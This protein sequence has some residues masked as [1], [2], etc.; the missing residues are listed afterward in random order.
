MKK[1]DILNIIDDLVLDF[2]IYDREEDEDI[3]PKKLQKAVNSGIITIDEMVEEFRKG[4][5]ENF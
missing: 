5:M 2:I 3:S 4:L 1:Q